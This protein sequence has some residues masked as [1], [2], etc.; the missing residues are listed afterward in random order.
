[1]CIYLNLYVLEWNGMEFSLISLQSTSI[2][3]D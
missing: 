1:M 2:H 3:V